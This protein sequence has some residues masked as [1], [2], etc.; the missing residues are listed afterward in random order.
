MQEQRP[1]RPGRA[2]A[3][4]A[5]RKPP[6]TPHF[7]ESAAAPGRDEPSGHPQTSTRPAPGRGVTGKTPGPPPTSRLG[8]VPGL[9]TDTHPQPLLPVRRCR[10]LALT[11]V[12]SSHGGPAPAPLLRPTPPP[13]GCA[14][15]R[16]QVRVRI[17]RRRSPGT[18]MAPPGDS[19]WR[20]REVS[21][22]TTGGRGPTGK[23][24]N[25]GQDM[26]IVSKFSGLGVVYLEERGKKQQGPGIDR[27]TDP[28]NQTKMCKYPKL[29]PMTCHGALE[30]RLPVG[31][32][33]FLPLGTLQQLPQSHSFSAEDVQQVVNTMGKQWFTLQPGDPGI[34]SHPSQSWSLPANEIPFFL[35]VNGVILIPGNADGFLLT[36]YFEKALQLRPTQKSLSL[37]GSDIVIMHVSAS[38]AFPG[39]VQQSQQGANVRYSQA[40]IEIFDTKH[41]TDAQVNP[42][43]R[44]EAAE[45]AAAGLLDLVHYRYQTCTERIHSKL[46]TPALSMVLETESKNNNTKGGDMTLQLADERH[47]LAE[48][49]SCQEVVQVGVG[50]V[51]GQLVQVEQAPVHELLQ[52]QGALHGLEAALSVVTAWLPDVLEVEAAPAL[53]LQAH[54]ALG[55]PAVLVGAAH[56]EPH[57]VLQ[58]HVVAVEVNGRVQAHE[59]GVELQGEMAVDGGPAVGVVALAQLRGRRGQ[60]GGRPVLFK[61]PPASAQLPKSPTT[62]ANLEFAMLRTHNRANARH[63][64]GLDRTGN[65]PCHSW[66]MVL[67][68]FQGKLVIT[69]PQ[70]D[71]QKSLITLPPHDNGSPKKRHILANIEFSMHAAWFPKGKRAT[72]G[73]RTHFEQGYNAPPGRERDASCYRTP[74]LGHRYPSNHLGLEQYKRLKGNEKI[75]EREQ[76]REAFIKSEVQATREQF[77]NTPINLQWYCTL[78]LQT[79]G[80]KIFGNLESKRTQTQSKIHHFNRE[81]TNRIQEDTNT[82]RSKIKETASLTSRDRATK[83]KHCDTHGKFVYALQKANHCRCSI[84][85]GPPNVH[86]A[87]VSL[88]TKD[89]YGVK[90]LLVDKF[91]DLTTS[92]I[93]FGLIKEKVTEGHAKETSAEPTVTEGHAK[94]TSA[95][96]TLSKTEE[97]SYVVHLIPC[98]D[99]DPLFRVILEGVNEEIAHGLPRSL[100]H[101]GLAQFELQLIRCLLKFLESFEG[102]I[103]FSLPVVI[104]ICVSFDFSLEVL[105]GIRK[106]NTRRITKQKRPAVTIRQNDSAEVEA[107]VNRLVNM[108][109]RASGTY[110]S[111][112]SYFHRHDAALE[113]LGHFFR[114]MPEGKRRAEASQDEWGETQGAV[115]AVVLAEENLNQA[116]V[117][118]HALGS[119]QSRLLDEQVKLIQ[120]MCNHLTNLRRPAGPQRGLG[121][122]LVERLGKARPPARLAGAAIT[123][124]VR[125]NEYTLNLSSAG[126]NLAYK[127]LLTKFNQNNLSLIRIFCKKGMS[128][129]LYEY[130]GIKLKPSE[131]T[132]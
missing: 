51:G 24:V 5:L 92:R 78:M 2:R 25:E 96:P 36:K 87:N 26:P 63:P 18:K 50:L 45:T 114:E 112:G 123:S 113:D 131:M 130:Y 64:T 68:I 128:D 28:R 44:R 102:L 94:E 56:E 11:P 77:T 41:K 105:Q 98:G 129:I 79:N 23:A 34:G 59:G 82:K 49:V 39:G 80:F 38:T 57:E 97:T 83:K 19:R 22:T 40:S 108:H 76:A 33:A 67:D 12:A 121:E 115:E 69:V 93:I 4:Q 10:R 74:L 91:C 37:A 3:R 120:M 29:G 116:L 71:G 66:A 103:Y 100:D 55:P 16:A 52:E 85:I 106:K 27:L 126:A 65:K 1:G 72:R 107:A 127:K 62:K 81:Q 17:E 101:F 70:V 60:R 99:I 132:E 104:D 125:A 43:G 84:T 30:L 111:L 90:R 95:E 58:G 118:L 122:S 31:V 48:V 73:Y 117:D 13:L 61:V 124:L 110:L 6:A 46:L 88:R 32:K 8:Q 47:L 7:P 20:S 119:A 21:P 54:Q 109:L 86:Y 35:S 9:L 15:R 75:Q 42:D 14:L 53:V 89:S